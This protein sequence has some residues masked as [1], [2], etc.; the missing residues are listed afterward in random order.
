MRSRR[1]IKKLSK[2]LAPLMR[3]PWVEEW[4]EDLYYKGK[5]FG[6]S[7]GVHH[8]GGESD[9]WGESSDIYTVL[10]AAEDGF[11]SWASF[12]GCQSCQDQFDPHIDTERC[13]ET[14]RRLKLR[15]TFNNLRMALELEA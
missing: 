8:V 13:E 10:E 6:N 7:K 3:N 9:Y 1:L 4:N 2:K 15:P 12:C 11:Y 5:H 14:K